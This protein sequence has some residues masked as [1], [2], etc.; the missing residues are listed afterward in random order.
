MPKALS[1]VPVWRVSSAAIR[2]ALA[3]VSRARVLRSPR[4]PIGVATTY[5]RPAATFVTI[6]LALRKASG[7]LAM[8]GMAA[9]SLRPRLALA[10]ALALSLLLSACSLLKPEQPEPSSAQERAQRLAV[11]GNHAQAAQTY[12]DLAAQLPADHD[13]YELLS[14]EQWVLANNIEQAKQGFAAV[15]PEARTTKIGQG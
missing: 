6:L 1:S 13:N 11:A 8:Q 5:R 12:A 10:A 3:S 15:S 4:L 14:A 7:E 9:I 2:A